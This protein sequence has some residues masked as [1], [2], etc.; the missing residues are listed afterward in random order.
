ML[1]LR[2]QTPEKFLPLTWTRATFE[3]RYGAMSPLERALLVTKDIV[4]QCREEIAADVRARTGLRVNDDFVGNIEY[5][6]QQSSAFDLP[7]DTPWQI[8]TN[9]SSFITDDFK[10]WRERHTNFRD[11]SLMNGAHIVGARED[12]CIDEGSCVQPGCVLDATNGPIILGKNV[13]VKWS[14]IQGPVFVGDNCVID[15]ARLRNGVSVGARCK[16]GG[17]VSASI[18]QGNA[19]KSHEGFVGNSWLG[20]WVNFGALA[21]TSN[22]KNTYGTI[23]YQCD[24]RTRI[25]T[26]VQFL[27]SIVGDHAKIGIG[28]MLTT[29]SNIGVGCNVFGGGVAPNY[30]PSFSWGGVGG[31]SEYRRDDFLK[32]TEQVFARRN[33]QL[34]P[35]A[36][37]VLDRVFAATQVERERFLRTSS[38]R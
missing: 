34:S 32:T 25:D 36:R 37:D 24:S 26:Q 4:L 16:I 18:F 20:E 13:V 21:T 12:V 23:R 38:T 15:G 33:L 31:W 27:G 1:V 11:E 7:F 10:S 28:Q 5:S 19:N 6:I 9:S 8:L 14:Q 30:V 2:E 22:L 17:E 3:L 29:G 35:S